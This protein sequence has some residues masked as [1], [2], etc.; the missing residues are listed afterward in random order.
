[1]P[2]ELRKH[3]CDGKMALRRVL[4]QVLRTKKT[5]IDKLKR[6][7]QQEVK[8]SDTSSRILTNGLYIQEAK[9][10]ENWT[11]RLCTCRNDEI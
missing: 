8:I 3:L 7:T 6:K 9:S 11:V 4:N 1:M 5:W 10:K 2:K